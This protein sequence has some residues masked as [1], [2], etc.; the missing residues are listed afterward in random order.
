MFFLTLN[1]HVVARSLDP[2]LL[3]RLGFV[4]VNRNPF[5]QIQLFRSEQ[6]RVISE[7]KQEGYAF[8]EVL[9]PVAFV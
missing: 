9:T 8:A 2:E 3:V 7:Q 5:A 6:A 4:L 1:N